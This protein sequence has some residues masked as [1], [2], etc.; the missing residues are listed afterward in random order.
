MGA[1]NPDRIPLSMRFTQCRTVAEMAAKRWDVISKCQTCELTMQVDLALIAK[2]SGPETMIWNRKARCRRLHCGGF[3]EFRARA[4]GMAWHE[5]LR[6]D[7]R[8]PEP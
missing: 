2:V 3:V 4:P 7:M 6:V 1:K 8:D 5:P